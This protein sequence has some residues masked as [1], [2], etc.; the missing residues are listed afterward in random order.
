MRLLGIKF[1]DALMLL[2]ALGIS[3]AGAQNNFPTPGGA[4]VPGYVTMC[5]TAGIAA[6]CNP[7]TAPLQAPS[8]LYSANGTPVP[9]CNAGSNGSSLVVSDTTAPTYRSTYTS[10]GTVT[11]R[12]LC[13]GGTWVN[14]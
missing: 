3:P 7:S 6:P 13:A 9:A 5:V 10:G 11:G 12:L 2:L 1:T 14:D 4:T 8:L